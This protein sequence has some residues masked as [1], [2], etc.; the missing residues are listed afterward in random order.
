MRILVTVLLGA[1]IMMSISCGKDK[2]DSRQR[3]FIS[4]KLDNRVYLSDSPKGTIYV[5]NFS[6]QNPDNDFPR[7]EITGQSYNGDVIT[8]TLTN[9]TLPFTPGVYPATKSGNGMLMAL[10][11]T[12][13]ATLSSEGSADFYITITNIDNVAVEGSF[14]G[15]LTD[16]SGSGGP[17]AVKDGAFRAVITPV[18][19]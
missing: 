4:L 5:P 2:D 7:M 11:S 17:R 12:S 14:S 13:P 6:D 18:S 16:I 9:A 1:V 3:R 8:F 19:Q 10:N 15:T